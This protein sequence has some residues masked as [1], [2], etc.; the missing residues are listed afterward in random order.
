MLCAFYEERA[1][2]SSRGR[3]GAS[4]PG[5]FHQIRLNLCSSGVPTCQD[6]CSLRSQRTAPE[7]ICLQTKPKSIFNHFYLE[8]PSVRRGGRPAVYTCSN[9][10]A[11]SARHSQS[12]SDEGTRIKRRTRRGLPRF[13]P[14][15]ARR[16]RR[17][18]FGYKRKQTTPSLPVV[19]FRRGGPRTPSPVW[20]SERAR[21]TR[22][23][24]LQETGPDRH[25]D[26]HQLALH[27]AS[28]LPEKKT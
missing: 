20:Q 3:S 8:V 21:L 13:T 16:C 14:E 6:P 19:S 26:P 18:F 10:H 5:S 17:L 23:F 24:K 2:K 28:P 15:R 11:A 12:I 7:H 1:I 25:Y 9:A 22:V 27:Q 4:G